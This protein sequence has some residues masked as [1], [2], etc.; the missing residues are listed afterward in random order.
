MNTGRVRPS[1]QV[2]LVLNGDSPSAADLELLEHCALIV[3]AD[4]GANLLID[5]GRLPH[6]VVGDLESLRPDVLETIEEQGVRIQAHQARKD[7][8]DGRLALEEALRAGPTQ[9]LVLGGHGGRT[10]MMWTN[11]DL[12][13]RCAEVGVHATMVG[14]DE[15]LFF[16]G[17]GQS[18]EVDAPAGT[19]FNVL[20]D[21]PDACYTATG[22]AYDVERLTLHY[23]SDRGVSNATMQTPTRI[24][25]HEGRVLLVVERSSGAAVDPF[26]S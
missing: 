25:V 14:H 26:V 18:Y 22:S 4:G 11:L 5:D 17:A 20:A 21:T 23:G 16:V 7:V 10:A 6:V 13:R 19:V 15:E 8:T 24:H 2:A 12:L 9:L 3:A 1:M